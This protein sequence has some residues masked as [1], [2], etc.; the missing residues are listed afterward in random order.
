MGG[1]EGE[2][3]REGEEWLSAGLALIN[4]DGGKEPWESHG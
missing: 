3:G 2:G 1:D 4:V